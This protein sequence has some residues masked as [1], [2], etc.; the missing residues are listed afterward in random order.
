MGK[1][2]QILL[3]IISLTPKLEK[4]FDLLVEAYFVQKYN[5][6]QENYRDALG[7]AKRGNT[8]KLREEIGK[9]L[10]VLVVILCGCAT[11]A[12]LKS[13][14]YLDFVAQ[15]CWVD[16]EAGEGYQFSQLAVEQK[17]CQDFGSRCWFA[18][19]DQDLERI[20]KRLSQ[21]R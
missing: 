19:T 13:L 4:L 3:A 1:L 11:G 10:P 7:E 18:I 12:P 17:S 5:I 8:K 20:H 2:A 14:C 16:R 6:N 9:F 21:G 15:V